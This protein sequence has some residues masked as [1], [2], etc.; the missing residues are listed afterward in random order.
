MYALPVAS[1]ITEKC[2]VYVVFVC[3]CECV[4]GL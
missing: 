1:D 2:G 4:C 3:M